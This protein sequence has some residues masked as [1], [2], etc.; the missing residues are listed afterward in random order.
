MPKRFTKML[1]DFKHAFKVQKVTGSKTARFINKSC[2]NL[3]F[4]NITSNSQ[5]NYSGYTS[6]KTVVVSTTKTKPQKQN[7]S[8]K[9]HFFAL[10]R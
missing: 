10:F 2:I 4:E 7:K 6:V 9:S 5:S 1:T 8:P 3:Y